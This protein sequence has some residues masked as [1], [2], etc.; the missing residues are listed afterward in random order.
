MEVIGRIIAR[1]GQVGLFIPF[2][3]SELDGVYNIIEV[4][5]ELQ[6]QRVGEAALP[7]QTFNGM[8]LAGLFNARPFS[9]MT[10]D[11]LDTLS[12]PR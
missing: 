8:D 4:M 5:G 12:I 9:C 1:G 11:E 10:R 2:K 3:V 6:I 7:K